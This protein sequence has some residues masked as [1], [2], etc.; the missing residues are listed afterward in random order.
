MAPASVAAVFP[1]VE[2]RKAA[3]ASLLGARIVMFDAEP[4]V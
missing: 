4:K 2:F 1:A 3:R